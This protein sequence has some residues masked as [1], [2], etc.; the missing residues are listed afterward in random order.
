MK[1]IQSRRCFR[2]RKS[3]SYMCKK[4]AKTDRAKDPRDNG[5]SLAEKRAKLYV[6]YHSYL[7]GLIN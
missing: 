4:S 2:V 5:S 1:F 3:G 7:S 6:K